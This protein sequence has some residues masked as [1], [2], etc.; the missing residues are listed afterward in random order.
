MI[1]LSVDEAQQQVQSAILPITDSEQIALGQAL[2]RITADN[3]VAPI[4][5]PAFDNSAMDGY[6]FCAQDLTTNKQ[7]HIVGSAF[8][9]H[10]YQGPMQSGQAI[11][12]TT[13]APIP[14]RCDAVLPQELAVLANA[15]TLDMRNIE[16]HAGQHRRRCGEDLKMGDI[17]IAKGCRLKPAELGLLASLGISNV[18]VRRRLR[19]ALFSTGDELRSVGQTLDSGCIY[20]SNRVTLHGMLNRFG[21]EVVDLGVLA[22]N[23]LELR[24]ALQNI[25]SQV[26]VIITSGGVAEGAADYTKQVMQELAEMTF[27]SINMRPGR[28]FAFGKMVQSNGN[29]FLFGLPG[30]PVAVMVSFYFFVRPA[31]QLRGGERISVPIPINAIAAHRISKKVGR[32]EFQRGI[33]TVTEHGQLCVTM[34]GEQ[35]SGILS[36]MSRAN[37]LVVLKPEQSNIATGDAVQLILFEGLT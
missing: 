13:G 32:T 3:I 5:V 23:P 14:D 6:A 12:I 30:N 15:H 34:T 35:G 21:A 26:D 25:S 37:C 11:R 16:V 27:L 2:D 20:D 28:P 19:V 29:T 8:A 33:C 9:G 1:T 36:S 22:D 18:K 10:P 31:L 17:A 24:T 7:L 4:N